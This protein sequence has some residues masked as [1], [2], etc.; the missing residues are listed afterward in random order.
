[1][2]MTAT[3]RAAHLLA[4]AVAIAAPLGA[5]RA[6]VPF[7]VGEELSYRVTFG[8]IPAGSAKMRVDAIDTIR[9]RP[10]Y[11]LVFLLDGGI[12]GY[13]VH[14]RYDSWMDVETLSSLRYRQQISEGPY[15]RT[16]V[17]EIFPE[18]LTFQKDSEPPEPSVARPLDDAS[19]I[20]AVR[21]EPPVLGE[22][23]RDDRYFR[24]DRNPVVLTA[25]R[26]DT[27]RVGAG[28]FPSLVVR[29]TIKT[30]GIFSENGRAEV[31]L[32]EDG[33]WYPVQLRTSFAGFS[34]AMKL[35]TVITGRD[36]KKL[37]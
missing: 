10:A 12:P 22:S 28:K 1:M 37:P 17:F 26:R 18:R 32:A 7:S 8:V 33:T 4:L 21:A 9:G 25:T 6:R 35:Q 29:P 13:R 19:F 34:L 2:Y 5:Q 24:R 27:I 16:S 14:D 20:Y 15:R 11:H 36:G 31:W 23:R 30:S 3:R